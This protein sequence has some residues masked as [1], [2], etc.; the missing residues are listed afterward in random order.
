MFEACIACQALSSDAVCSFDLLPV[1]DISSAMQILPMMQE[2]VLAATA[3]SASEMP[4][5]A[6]YA[7]AKLIVHKAHQAETDENTPGLSLLFEDAAFAK[8]AAS[9]SKVRAAKA[10]VRRIERSQAAALRHLDKDIGSEDF[11]GMVAELVHYK[12]QQLQVEIE[13]LA[14]V[15][16]DADALMPNLA[17]RP[18]DQARLMKS[19]QKS[20]SAISNRAARLKAWVTGSFVPADILPA[21]VL[22]L[23][24]TAAEWDLSQ[25][26]RGVFPWQSSCNLAVG[27]LTQEQLISRLVLR[28]RERRRSLEEMQLLQDEKELSLR[29]YK[30]QEAALQDALASTREQVAS[31]L[32][33]NDEAHAADELPGAEEDPPS[34]FLVSRLQ[35]IVHL[36]ERRLERV[37]AIQA[38]AQRA[39]GSHGVQAISAAVACAP[40]YLPDAIIVEDDDSEE[41]ELEQ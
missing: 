11:Q 41:S 13:R 28:T 29:L 22:A 4:W 6:Q 2:H 19:L 25:M 16:L 34:G 30:T 31:L 3:S 15:R 33:S 1:S 7:E 17:E 20:A 36:L 24:E 9:S 39:F 40:E 35:G 38:A 26:C 18:A 5:A 14:R 8:L 12:I 27:E 23:R 32:A 21:D 37:A 10:T